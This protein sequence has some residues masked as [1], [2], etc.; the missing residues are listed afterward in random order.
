MA[1]EN[2]KNIVGFRRAGHILSKPFNA[3][4]NTTNRARALITLEES[5][6][7]NLVGNTG[8]E[9]DATEQ[10]ISQCQHWK[11][12]HNKKKHG[13]SL[14]T[15]PQPKML[16][17]EGDSTYGISEDSQATV[18]PKPFTDP[19]ATLYANADYFATVPARSPEPPNQVAQDCGDTA[20]LP[21][22]DPAGLQLGQ[23]ITR[24]VF[25]ETLTWRHFKTAQDF[26][27]QSDPRTYI[28]G[29][30]GI[31]GIFFFRLHETWRCVSTLPDT[32]YRTYS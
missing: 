9:S 29:S 30:E 4:H 15:A 21:S 16:E 22:T 26:H 13:G 3:Q 27:D 25:P 1:V 18:R 31:E 32:P 6:V 8:T 12:N 24:R 19:N 11:Q 5:I 7:Q 17:Q 20:L 28:L 14:H 10:D 2:S 23:T